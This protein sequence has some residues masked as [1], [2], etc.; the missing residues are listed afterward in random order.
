MEIEIYENNLSDEIRHYLHQHSSHSVSELQ[1]QE[2]NKITKCTVAGKFCDTNIVW[3]ELI[4]FYGYKLFTIY[5]YDDMT[6]VLI[7]SYQA[8]KY[9]NILDSEYLQFKGKFID[10]SEQGWLI[11]NDID[12]C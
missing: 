1:T 4:N 2:E 3:D 9:K 7:S 5:T 8:R 11:V 12:I 6:E 10:N